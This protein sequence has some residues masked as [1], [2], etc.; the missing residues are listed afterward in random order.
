MS[1][2]TI[3]KASAGSGKTF[4]LTQEYL[5]LLINDPFRYRNILAVTFTN[6]AAAEMKSR[7]LTE[8]INLSQKKESKYLDSLQK[9]TN[10]S[11]TQIR[12]KATSALFY[13]L[14]DYSH[15]DIET[16]DKFFQRVVRSFAR[17]AGL[18]SNFQLEIDPGL[19][20]N[21]SIDRLLDSLGDNKTLLNWMSEYVQ[22]QIEQGS[23]WNVRKS[24]AQLGSYLFQETYA[25]HANEAILKYSDKI[26]MSEYRTKLLAIEKKYEQGCQKLGA[27]FVSCI[28]S[29]GL[30][31]ADFSYGKT[32]IAG[33]FKKMADGEIPEFSGTRFI[34]AADG[35]ESWYKKGSSF[36][37][38]IESLWISNLQNYYQQAIDLSKQKQQYDTA[39]LILENFG[40]LAL[41]TDIA[42]S[43]SEINRERN[44]FLLSD[45][46][47][48][49]R[50]VIAGN[51]APFIY[52][53]AGTRYRHYMLDEFQDTSRMQWDNFRPLISNSLA[54]GDSC[55]VVGDVK[56]SIYRWRNGDWRLL[57]YRLASDFANWVKEST[58]DTNRRSTQEVVTF[59]NSF[60]AQVWK[61]LFAVLQEKNV[62]ESFTRMLPE[63]Y[64][65][66]C[67][68]LPGKTEKGYVEVCCLEAEKAAEF[69]IKATE[70]AIRWYEQLIDLGVPA[71]DIAFIVRTNGEG[72]A[73]AAAM[74]ERKRNKNAAY[75]YDVIS[76][77]AFQLGS[78]PAVSFIISLLKTLLKPD[79][80]VN[81]AFLR[82]EY[83]NYLNFVTNEK[84]YLPE[85]P[86]HDG[87]ILHGLDNDVIKLLR[88]IPLYECCEQIVQ[89]FGLGKMAG[90]TPFLDAFFDMLADYLRGNPADIELFVQWWADKG[91][92]KCLPAPEKME[93][94]TIIT[95]HKS[96]GLEF[97][98]VI[99][100][101]CSW[102]LVKSGDQG[103]L[104]CKPDKKPFNE[105]PLVPVKNDK[106]LADTFF[107]KE[108]E[109]EYTLNYLD[110]LNLLYVAFTR[111]RRHLF[112]AAWLKIEKSSKSKSQLPALRTASDLLINGLKAGVQTQSEY[113]QIALNEY[114]NNVHNLWHIGDL[115]APV[116]KEKIKYTPV[117]AVWRGIPASNRLR[118]KYAHTEFLP[119]EISDILQLPQRDKGK[120]LHRLFAGIHTPADLPIVLSEMLNE[121]IISQKESKTLTTEVYKALQQPQAA[122]WFSANAKVMP[123]ASIVLPGG[124][125]RRPDRVMLFNN[126]TVVVDFKFGL[127]E[128]DDYFFQVGQYVELLQKMGNP[129]VEG[130][131]W[132][133]TLNRT[134]RVI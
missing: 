123:E 38:Q 10:F 114:W 51:E 128:K 14:H 106:K 2:L 48:L 16:I 112:L 108:Y 117:A 129:S 3:Y 92:N 95:I 37:A 85:E 98:S 60:F 76:G 90:Q 54:Q 27:D 4:T 18:Q 57:S 53:K 56:Q 131:L 17:E 40:S 21:E 52:E 103:L 99:M 49:L 126:R 120:L 93:A 22:E 44:Q 110:N 107:S 1:L 102:E 82:S 69:R 61:L 25:E 130:W 35:P 65:Q 97:S 78:S 121:G 63:A 9:D 7:I 133:V 118:L 8:L 45:T 74:Q 101:Y 119:D 109:E 94:A 15:F 32:G 11:E 5:R 68:Q 81:N 46:S 24:M 84:N 23:S 67:Q 77:E 12:E 91:A 89:L 13:I 116:E 64:L 33:V 83:H 124:E 125:Q 43:I 79:D 115:Q 55:L 62:D 73:L 20:L 96:K 70:Q 34:K 88:I 72:Q 50:A 132:Y 127:T 6:K 104:W 29:N 75:T 36:K 39:S 28:E 30:Q 105:L 113:P 111:A 134:I 59:N 31:I 87:K 47:Q 58:L 41:L 80:E 71:R 86:V 26:F 42:K 100:P 66:P 19:L 122:E